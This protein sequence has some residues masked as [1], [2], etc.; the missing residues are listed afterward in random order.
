MSDRRRWKSSSCRGFSLWS[1]VAPLIAVNSAW[2]DE[3]RIFT[4]F[5]E[6]G[7]LI[8]RTNSACSEAPATPESRDPLERWC[9]E[10]GAAILMPRD[11]I[12]LPAR[13]TDLATL[14]RLARELKVS[15]RAMAIRLIGLGHAGWDL[16]RTIPPA[17]DAKPRGGGGT[18]R[19]RREIRQDE[20]GWRGTE[21][22]V[23]AVQHDIISESQALDYLDIP[24]AEF[25]RLRSLT[26]TSA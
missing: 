21:L 2:R 12:R 23:A 1:D 16:Y 19:N 14:S 11:A 17:S 7:H 24:A 13:V 26:P 25:E 5:H 15:L 4:V 18:G 8:T 3:A 22:F 9:E 6:F 10:F 20:I